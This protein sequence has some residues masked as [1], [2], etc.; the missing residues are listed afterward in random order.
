MHINWK[1]APEV[2]K[3][4]SWFKNFLDIDIPDVA[5]PEQSKTRVKERIKEALG[6]AEDPCEKEL[7]CQACVI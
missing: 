2:S 5:Y 4:K 7:F 6:D 3:A 1:K